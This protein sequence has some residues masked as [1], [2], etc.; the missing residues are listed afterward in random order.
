[1]KASLKVALRYFKY[2]SLV[3]LIGYGILIAIDD[4]VFIERISSIS[5]FGLFFGFEFLYM[6]VYFLVFSFYFWLLA[7][8]IIIVYQKVYKPSVN[9]T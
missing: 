5:D 1:M 3:F 9:K 2:A 7:F 6:L 4:Y 8:T